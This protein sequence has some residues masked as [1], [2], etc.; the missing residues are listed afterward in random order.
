VQVSLVLNHKGARVSGQVRAADDY[1]L[2]RDGRVMLLWRSPLASLAFPLP[3]VG[4]IGPDGAFVISGV[5]P[6]RYEISVRDG[7]HAVD[8]V[9]GPREVEVPIEPGSI[10]ALREPVLVRRQISGE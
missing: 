7:S 10:V 5:L 3:G 6:G 4:E 2:G 9:Q 1:R 8:V